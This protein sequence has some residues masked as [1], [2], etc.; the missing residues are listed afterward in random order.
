MAGITP[1]QTVGPFFHY[2]LT[3]HDYDFAA[4]F[5]NNLVTPEASGERIR[6]EGRVLDGD[7]TPINDCM[8]EIWQA[9]AAGR[10]AHPADDRALPYGGRGADHG[11]PPVD[12]VHVL[13]AGRDA[14]VALCARRPPRLL[15]AVPDRPRQDR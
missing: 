15:P 14:R 9:D 2:G 8:V 6:I 11:R 3:P 13:A 1:S 5:G 10:Y 12:G 7:G 4:V